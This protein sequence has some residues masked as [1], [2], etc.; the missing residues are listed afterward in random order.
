MDGRELGDEF[1]N[2]NV[3]L[4]AKNATERVQMDELNYQKKINPWKLLTASEEIYEY[5]NNSTKKRSVSEEGLVVVASLLDHFPNLGGLCRTCEIFGANKYVVSS[6]KV[7]NDQ[8]FQS[9]SVS[10]QNWVNILE[11]CS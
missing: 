5:S 1:P 7:I 2:D 8:Q 10:A 6:L 11:V 3:I 4:H 9:L